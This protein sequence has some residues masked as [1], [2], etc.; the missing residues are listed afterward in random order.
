MVRYSGSLT[1]RNPDNYSAIG[2]LKYRD[3]N[4]LAQMTDQGANERVLIGGDVGSLH[5][6]QGNGDTA[7][8]GREHTMKRVSG[9]IW[10]TGSNKQLTLGPGYSTI[11]VVRLMLV[12]DTQAN[13]SE[14]RDSDIAD[15]I[16]GAHPLGY[17]NLDNVFRFK[18][19][20]DKSVMLNPKGGSHDGTNLYAVAGG[21]I[22]K[23]SIP[24][25]VKTHSLTNSGDYGACA[26]NKL[27]LLAMKSTSENVVIHHQ[28]R[29]RFTDN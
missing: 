14:T 15:I 25:N 28:T 2:E 29:L 13:G 5:P 9:T 8:I 10:V 22:L 1:A 4:G 19:L 24:L 7:R 21:E 6:F 23:F 27:V 16:V 11:T 20:W 17:R 12:L 18:V 26:D 3:Y